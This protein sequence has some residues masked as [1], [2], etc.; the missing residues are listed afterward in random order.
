MRKKFG[1]LTVFGKNFRV[2]KERK[3]DE[4]IILMTYARYSFD[5]L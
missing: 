1:E 4:E 2:G 5:I 3:R